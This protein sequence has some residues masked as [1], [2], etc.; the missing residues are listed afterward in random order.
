MTALMGRLIN[1]DDGEDDPDTKS[2]ILRM[3]GAVLYEDDLRYL[4]PGMY[5]NDGVI[6]FALQYVS[7]LSLDYTLFSSN[8]AGAWKIG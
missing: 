8:P 2:P 6:Y 1:I 4:Q 5:A 7:H 3:G